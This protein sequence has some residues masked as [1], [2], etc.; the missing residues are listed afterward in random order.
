MIKILVVHNEPGLCELI[1]RSFTGIGYQTFSANDGRSTLDTVKNNHPDVV[2]LD[3]NLPDCHSLDILRA[4]K[5]HNKNILVFIIS[6]KNDPGA[7]DEALA[8]GAT[9]F[10]SKPFG[11]QH[12]RDLIATNIHRIRGKN[13]KIDIP[14]MLIVDNEESICFSLKQYLSNRLKVNITICFNGEQ[15]LDILQKSSFDIALVDITMSGISGLDVIEQMKNKLRETEFI[16]MTGW[17]S[18]EVA[19][20]A[21]KKG[22]FYYLTKPLDLEGLLKCVRIILSEKNKLILT[23][24]RQEKQN[25]DS[26]T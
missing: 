20:R 16:V 4:I 24:G 26:G 17:K 3:Y 15:A 23:E 11:R 8:L 21:Q 6:T 18:S 9:G 2:F 12:L 7:N 19:Q 1:C 10:V 5:E 22:V 25:K 14:N 13:T